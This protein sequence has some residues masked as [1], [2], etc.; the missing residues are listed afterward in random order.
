MKLKKQDNQVIVEMDQK[1]FFE[2]LAI[3]DNLKKLAE[4]QKQTIETLMAQI[5]ELTKAQ[6]DVF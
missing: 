3:M 5:E 2:M 4:E 6:E 1:K